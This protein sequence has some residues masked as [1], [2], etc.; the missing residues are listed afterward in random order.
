MIQHPDAGAIRILVVEDERIVALDLRNALRDLGFVVL[1]ISASE[2][3]AC[4]QARALRPD[5]VLM[6]INLGRGGDGVTAAQCIAR[7]LDIPVVYLTAYAGVEHLERAS[8][9]PPYGYLLK[10]IEVRELNATLHMAVARHRLDRERLRQQRQAGQVFEASADAIAVLDPEDRVQAVNPAFE[11]LTGWTL[12]EVRG[13]QPAE[14]LHARRA[15]DRVV[16]AGGTRHGEVV[17]RRRDGSFFPAWEHLAE[18]RDADGRLTQRVLTFSDISP[19]RQ[20]SG[21]I[22]HL[23]FHDP[24]T[25]LPNRHQFEQQLQAML[26]RYERCGEGFSLLFLDLDGFK[27]VNDSLGHAQGDRLLQTV[28]QRLRACLRQQDFAARLG[29]DEFV[30]LVAGTQPEMLAQ[31]AHKL[32]AACR[33][34][35]ELDARAQLSA[36]VGVASLPLHATGVQELVEAADVAMYAAKQSGRDAVR[37]HSAALGQRP[38]GAAR[39]GQGPG[40]RAAG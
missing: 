24:L 30:V 9:M 22:H 27:A 37:F 26:A 39:A 21:Q 1:G 12:D 7:E 19:L 35:F 5:L 28:A 3:E 2:A 16:T 36:S 18:V 23:A 17:C 20:Q 10:P 6:D 31:V 14:F 25:G 33:E 29:G 32:L 4:E 34:P 15:G 13:R 38:R 8:Q 11:A 40:A